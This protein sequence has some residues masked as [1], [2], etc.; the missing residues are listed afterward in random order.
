MPNTIT[1]KDL[2]KEMLPYFANGMNGVSLKKKEATDESVSAFWKHLDA[3][4]S[5]YTHGWEQSPRVL[6][7]RQIACA[8]LALR[9]INDG[10]N[11]FDMAHET[12]DFI[13]NFQDWDHPVSQSELLVLSSLCT[14]AK[15]HLALLKA[16][17]RYY[18][19]FWK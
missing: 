15:Q 12:M 14:I 10:K 11:I 17:E 8:Q 5:E 18:E 3:I 9:S 1:L 7:E 4:I 6:S 19:Q 2:H 13:N 16:N